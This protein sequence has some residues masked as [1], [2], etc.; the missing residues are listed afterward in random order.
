M[1]P[2]PFGTAAGRTSTEEHDLHGNCDSQSF[3]C[4]SANEAGALPDG[5]KAMDGYGRQLSHWGNAHLVDVDLSAAW[6]LFGLSLGYDWLREDLTEDEEKRIREKLILQGDRMYKFKVETEGSGW[7]TNYWQNHNW[8]NLTGL[9]SAGYALRSGYAYAKDWIECAKD[10]F[11]IVYDV[12]A[13]DGSDYEGVVY[14]RYG[15]MWLFVY[16][17]LLKE[18]EGIDYF[19][20]SGF[21]ENTFYYRL[22][23]AAPNLEEQINFGDCHD[24]R[25]GHSTAIYYKVAAEYKNGHAQKI[26][27]LVV[28]DF[29]YREAMDSEVKPG[30]LPE[31]F[32]EMIFYDPE[33]E[34]E[35]FETLPLQRY[36]EDLGLLVVRDS[37]ER[38]AAHLSFKCGHPGGKQQWKKLWELK[39][40]KNYN[41]FGLSHH[42]PDNNSFI[43]HANGKFMA[44]DDG[45]NRT[46]K[47]SDHNVVIVDGKGFANENQNNVYKNYEEDM[48]GEIEKIRIEPSYTYIV[49]ETSGTYDKEL[50]LTRN[51]RHILTTGKVTSSF[52]MSLTVKRNI[53]T[54]GRC[55]VMYFP[56]SMVRS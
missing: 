32:F 53:S 24:R 49:G 35:A 41:C 22:Y 42:H 23:Q 4:I 38:D 34:E 11:K 44:I 30:I 39:K 7:S 21:L 54:A 13:D 45:Y 52:S 3:P 50:K 56:E 31:V 51:A 25:S 29:L 15:A 5:S 40:E 46:V 10:N 43:L 36:F 20:S 1:Q 17:H 16:A 48:V 9:A 8:I 19:R 18:R 12:M 33:V 47:A 28:N 37:W 14:W 55:T 27:N 26:G 6:I 2:I